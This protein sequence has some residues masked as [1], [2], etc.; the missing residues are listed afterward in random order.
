MSTEF[1][2]VKGKKAG[3]VKEIYITRFYGGEKR[4]TSIQLTLDNGIYSDWIELDNKAAKM[5]AL[6]ILEVLIEME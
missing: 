6:K 2:S 3:D 5:L 1:G 4:G